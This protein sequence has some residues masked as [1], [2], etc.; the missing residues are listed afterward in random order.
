MFELSRRTVLGT[1]G[2]IGAGAALAGQV[3]ATA[4]PLPA[5]PPASPPMSAS[6][7]GPAAAYA[8]LRRLLP[9]TPTSSRC[10]SSTAPSV[11]G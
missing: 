1:A 11:S 4:A 8:A 10:G 7:S 2:A 9:A 6:P 5:T 3:P